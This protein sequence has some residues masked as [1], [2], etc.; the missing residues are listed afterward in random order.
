MPWL[1][2][3]IKDSFCDIVPSNKTDWAIFIQT[4]QRANMFLHF[5][6]DFPL[7]SLSWHIGCNARWLDRGCQ[8]DAILDVEKVSWICSALNIFLTMKEHW[9][10][11]FTELTLL[12][13]ATG[14]CASEWG[15]RD[16]IHHARIY[17]LR[18]AVKKKKGKKHGIFRES[19]RE[20]GRRKNYCTFLI[21]RLW[22]IFCI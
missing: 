22:N 4:S 6:Y 7:G 12:D 1:C 13:M 11:Y 2:N 17:W 21:F 16:I 15:W 18:E 19:G 8:L 5:S 3:N 14:R 20:T 9:Q 10:A